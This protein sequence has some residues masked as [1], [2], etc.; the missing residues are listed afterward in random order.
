MHYT[1]V[2]AGTIAA[3][4]TTAAATSGYDVVNYCSDK[5]YLTISNNEQGVLSYNDELPAGTSRHYDI[6]GD[7]SLAVANST[8]YWNPSTAKLVL[9]TNSA[10]GVL[11]YAMGI[12]NSY[13]LQG[14]ATT[15]TSSSCPNIT[16]PDGSTKGCGDNNISFKWTLCTDVILGGPI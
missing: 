1:T 6:V 9:G 13:P 15:F 5:K 7:H 4:C 12:A 16:T 8:D 14:R 11:Y 10:G 2:L 3:L